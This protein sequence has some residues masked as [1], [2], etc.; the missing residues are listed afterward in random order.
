MRYIYI[1]GPIGIESVSLMD[2]YASEGYAPILVT[3]G[4]TLRGRENGKIVFES[5]WEKRWDAQDIE[6]SVLRFQDHWK[7]QASSDNNKSKEFYDYG[8]DK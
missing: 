2:K 4:N 1:I 8:V 6:E 7:D 5:G 3:D